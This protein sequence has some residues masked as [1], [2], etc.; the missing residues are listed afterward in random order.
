[1][2]HEE[3]DYEDLIIRKAR[4]HYIELLTA[5]DHDEVLILSTAVGTLMDLLG[6]ELPDDVTVLSN[7]PWFADLLVSS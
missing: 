3:I 7:H 2:T 4:R 6:E 1:M 5:Q